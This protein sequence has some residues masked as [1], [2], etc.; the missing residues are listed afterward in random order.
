[1]DILFPQFDRGNTPAISLALI[2][3]RDTETKRT[4]PPQESVPLSPKKPAREIGIG[5]S[6]TFLVYKVKKR[7]KIEC[8]NAK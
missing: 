6:E 7:F 8:C 3:L 2:T 5:G 4:G 1:M